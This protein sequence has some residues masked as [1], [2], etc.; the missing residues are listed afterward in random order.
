MDINYLIV[1]IVVIAALVLL[2]WLIRRNL[3]D[4]KEFEKN[5]NLSELKP[6]LHKPEK[7]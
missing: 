6:D 3:K 1:G 7:M 4:K 2:M 5:S